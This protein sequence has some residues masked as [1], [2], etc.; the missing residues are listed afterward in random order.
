MAPKITCNET[1]DHTFP[2]LYDYSWAHILGEDFWEDFEDRSFHKNNFNP[3]KRTPKEVDTAAEN[4]ASELGIMLKLFRRE[5]TTVHI[6]DTCEYECDYK[7]YFDGDSMKCS[8]PVSP[9][10]STF[11]DPQTGLKHWLGP[12]AVEKYLS[13]ICCG[14]EENDEVEI[15]LHEGFQRLGIE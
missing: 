11:I 15:F 8:I 12:L 9:K 7:Q 14:L 10:T 3:K 5:A 1:G 2:I 6:Y 13:D 4:F